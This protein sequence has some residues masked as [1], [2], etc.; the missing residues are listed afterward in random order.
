MVKCADPTLSY[1]YNTEPHELMGFGP[2][3]AKG[4][5]WSRPMGGLL[6]IVAG[7]QGHIRETHA[8]LN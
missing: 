1:K 6:F 5:C 7:G 2:A 4:K 8:S 3:P